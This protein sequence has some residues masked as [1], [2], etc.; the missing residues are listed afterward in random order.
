[1]WAWRQAGNLV[2]PAEQGS[3]ERGGPRSR[4]P[5]PFSVVAP[6]GDLFE[7][8]VGIAVCTETANEGVVHGVTVTTQLSSHLVDAA[9][10][11]TDL[12]GGPAGGPGGQHIT[13]RGD[14]AVLLGPRTDLTV[15]IGTQQSALVPR[16]PCRTPNTGRSTQL[17]AERSFSRTSDRSQF[18]WS[19]WSS[20]DRTL[21]S[22]SR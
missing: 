11:T 7:G 16:K 3:S 5:C 6:P 9:G 2:P 4:S 13:R 17:D 10:M 22:L 14:P 8:E 19:R 15:V 21:A 12:D 1:M 20:P 18:G